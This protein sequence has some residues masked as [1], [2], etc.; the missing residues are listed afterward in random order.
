MVD[1]YAI[2][3]RAVETSKASD[4]GW[5]RNL[6]DRARRT[7]GGEMRA[8][9]PQPSQAEIAREFMAL[10]GA[11]RR[12]E[13]ER[14]RSQT[15]EDDCPS[16]AERDQL[17]LLASLRSRPLFLIGFALVVS[18]LSAGTY[19]LWSSHWAATLAAQPPA[20]KPGS[21]IVS[22]T[23]DGDLPPGIDGGP[24]DADQSYVFRRQPTFCSRS[25][26]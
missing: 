19:A 5:R 9:R 23:K 3:S 11:V 24:M 12:V 16:P 18:A 6:Y 8:R 1:Y 7:L 26:P 13:A 21:K 22:T 2:L 17:P 10:E 14:A 20:N 4:R 15:A 25:A